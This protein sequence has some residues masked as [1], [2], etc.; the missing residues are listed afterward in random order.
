MSAIC[1]NHC[2]PALFMFPKSP[3]VANLKYSSTACSEPSLTISQPLLPAS[4][5]LSNADT[6]YSC[7]SLSDLPRFFILASTAFLADAPYFTPGSAPANS[8]ASVG[9]IIFFGYL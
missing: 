6:I 9:G 3:P 8:T 5:S 4:N 2:F 1:T 7:R